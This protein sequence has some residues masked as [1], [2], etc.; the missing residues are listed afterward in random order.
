MRKQWIPGSL[1]PPPTES[2]GTRLSATLSKNWPIQCFKHGD[3]M[4][5][6][7]RIIL[8]FYTKRS[9]ILMI[10][11]SVGGTGIHIHTYDTRWSQHDM[12]IETQLAMYR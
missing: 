7:N 6:C 2:L 3:E 9:L 8:D 11:E 4:E 10:M 12:S 5:L 1:F